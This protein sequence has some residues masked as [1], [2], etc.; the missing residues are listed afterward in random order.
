MVIRAIWGGWLGHV[1]YYLG[2]ET[3]WLLVQ[4][5][6][7]QAAHRLLRNKTSGLLL[8]RTYRKASLV[9]QLWA[10]RNSSSPLSLSKWGQN[11]VIPGINRRRAKLV[12]ERRKHRKRAGVLYTQ[13]RRY[14]EHGRNGMHVTTD[15]E[16]STKP[17]C[18]RL[19]ELHAK[20]D[21]HT[22]IWHPKWASHPGKPQ[23][24]H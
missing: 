18:R 7:I 14:Q 6:A 5:V 24:Q 10:Y 22:L 9:P 23:N 17:R 20:E 2:E 8:Q 1:G 4:D 13:I 11:Q 16:P 3:R 21:L 12:V 19:E 15:G